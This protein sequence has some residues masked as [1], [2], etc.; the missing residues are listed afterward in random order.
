[1]KRVC[2]ITGS[3]GLLGNALCA[4]LS[5]NFEVVAAYRQNPPKCSSQ[6][7]RVL[8]A[9][10]CPP[11]EDDSLAGQ[12]YAVQGNLTERA[13]IRRLVE[14]TLARFNRVDVLINSAADT[15]FYG[16]LID[17]WHGDRYALDQMHLN[18]I[19]PM[20]LVSAI[21]HQSWKDDTA[22]SAILNRCVI[23][24]SSISGL[25]AVGKSGQAIYSA[26]KA[27]LN[28]L[29]MHLAL[30]LAPY[31]I[32]VNAICPSRFSDGETTAKV[33]ASVRALMDGEMT[34]TV[35]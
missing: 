5:P 27:A 9:P 14:V 10:G 30:E 19:A 3:G 4:A 18:S 34:G 28:M 6:V 1:M 12:V 32:R 16:N 29:T 13:D 15:R 22:K 7:K 25:Y 26:S 2:L 21:F 33:V 17:V 8:C 31:S 23:N 20:E 24:V 35:V 11:Q